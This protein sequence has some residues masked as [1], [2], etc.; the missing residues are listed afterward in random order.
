MVLH[1]D[2]I[3]RSKII[4]SD[5]SSSAEATVYVIVP[6]NGATSPSTI[7]AASPSADATYVLTPPVTPLLSRARLSISSVS[8][9]KKDYMILFVGSS[10]DASAAHS[11][12]YYT[13]D[14]S[15]APFAGYSSVDAQLKG[16]VNALCQQNVGVVICEE[17][18]ML[19]ILKEI[20]IRSGARWPGYVNI[21]ISTFCRLMPRMLK[22]NNG[23]R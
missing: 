9:T 23:S 2:L 8:G 4:P 19:R 10:G 17:S 7:A 14:A 5:S 15:V 21:E 18:E 22:E 11:T 12:A 3:S 6:F 1:V 13:S 16:S 20:F